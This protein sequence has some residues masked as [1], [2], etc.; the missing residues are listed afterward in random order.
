MPLTDAVIKQ[1]KPRDADYWLSDEK[2]MRLLIKKNGSKYWRLKYRF[3]GKQKTLALGVY[4]GVSLKAARLGRD[5]ARKLLS[6]HQDPSQ[7]KQD[8]K[9][10]SGKATDSFSVIALEWWNQQKGTWTDDHACRVW[11]RLEDNCSAIW[12]KSIND[13]EAHEVVSVVR[14]IEKRDAL[15]VAGRVLQDINR[16]GRYA[17]QTGVARYNPASELSG[18]TKNRKT[19]HRAS[20]PREAM[21]RFLLDL[22][23]YQEKGRLL[24]QLAIQLLTLT[25]VRPG[26]LRGALWKEFDFEEQLW[27]IPSERMKMRTE[28]LVP[29]SNQALD[30]IKKIQTISGQY[31]LLFPSERN[32]NVPMSDNT[33]RR[34][35]F[36]LGYDGNTAGKP[37]ANPH[38]FRATASS[39][40]NEKGYNPDA[41]ERQ[42][43]HVERNGVRAAYIHH[44]RF[45]DERK[46]MM[47]WWGSYLDELRLEAISGN[48]IQVNFQKS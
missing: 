21:P 37:K 14:Q 28:H 13:I 18:V 9:T 19:E 31:E 7:V 40:L 8:Q 16:V 26:E 47:S 10:K 44:A 42:L 27:R 12:T 34:A 46:K 41:I 2:G 15:D 11:K 29:L 5:D 33:M 32:R 30:V 6:L 43:S 36:R 45:L 1:A 25:F 35:I 17:V 4:P 20:L 39:I 38:G 23:R 3:G 22:S 24:T 48:V